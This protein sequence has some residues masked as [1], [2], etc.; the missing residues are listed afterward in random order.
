[1]GLLIRIVSVHAD[2]SL[3]VFARNL[4]G[5]VLLAPIML[6]QSG[7]SS[8]KTRKPLLHLARALSGLSA[9]Y[10]FF[11][12]LAHI[13]LANA[14]V[15]TYSAPVFIPVVAW[16]ALNE[17]INARII[18]ATLLGLTGVVLVCKPH[19]AWFNLMSLIGIASALLAAIAF[20][21]VRALTATESPQRIVFYFA[22]IST[23]LSLIPYSLSHP[24]DPSLKWQTLFQLG[25]IG[26][27]A[28]LS[29]LCLSKAYSLAPAS[30]IGPINYLAIVISGGY[31]WVL[32]GEKPDPAAIAGAAMILIATYLC[33]GKNPAKEEHP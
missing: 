18:S 7:M 12:A 25:G 30:R 17:H 16:L 13:P 28:T 15:F 27:L 19:A 8:M 14:M 26:A 32:W 21:S 2:N 23:L 22:A 5:V 4:V 1:M 31:A 33:L 11:Y 10:G 3:I 9:M 20:V 29:Q 6:I 24:H